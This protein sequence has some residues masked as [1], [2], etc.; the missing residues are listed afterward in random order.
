MRA[1][2]PVGLFFDQ[3][4]QPK[5]TP[6]P[7]SL[8][9]KAW[10]SRTCRR[11]IPRCVPLPRRWSG[12]GA[13]RRHPGV[14]AADASALSTMTGA[15]NGDGP[16]T[17]PGPGWNDGS[18]RPPTAASPRSSNHAGRPTDARTTSSGPSDSVTPTPGPRHSTTRSRSPSTWPT[19]SATPTTS[20]P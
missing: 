2:H 13:R 8:F 11:T 7:K 19:S 6:W 9:K 1:S 4:T 10:L 12:C 17:K 20:S 16:S 3:E 14:R 15:A 18:S 5:K